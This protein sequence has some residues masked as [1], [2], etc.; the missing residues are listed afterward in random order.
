MN[1]CV[2]T[3]EV[4]DSGMVECDRRSVV[5]FCSQYA[6]SSDST[7]LAGIYPVVDL[8]QGVNGP[9]KSFIGTGSGIALGGPNPLSLFR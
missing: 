2:P 7:L 3:N 8:G 4:T 5:R 9:K 1:L 6:G